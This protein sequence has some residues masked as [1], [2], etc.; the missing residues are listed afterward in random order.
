MP[1]VELSPPS[2]TAGPEYAPWKPYTGEVPSLVLQDATTWTMLRGYTLAAEDVFIARTK[3]GAIAGLEAVYRHPDPEVEKEARPWTWGDDGW[4]MTRRGVTLMFGLDELSVRPA[5]PV[6]VVEGPKD[7]ERGARVRFPGHVAVAR[8]GGHNGLGE[9]PTEYLAGRVVTIW[10][11]ADKVGRDAAYRLA[12]RLKEAGV[13]ALVVDTRGLPD[14]WGLADEPPAGVDLGALLAGARDAAELQADDESSASGAAT[15]RAILVQGGSLAPNIRELEAALISSNVGLYRRGLDLV[16]LTRSTEEADT[17]GIKRAAGALTIVTASEHRLMELAASAAAWFKPD[18]RKR[19]ELVQT[20]PPMDLLRSYLAGASERA[21][22]PLRGIVESPILR[23]DGTILEAPGYDEGTGL[24]HAPAFEPL[25]VA[26]HPTR[27]DALSALAVLQEPLAGFPFDTPADKS[28]ALAAILTPFVRRSLLGAPLF[29]FDAPKPRVGKSLLME[30]V[31]RIATGRAASMMSYSLDPRE[32]EKRLFSALLS[33]DQIICIDNIDPRRA[34]ESPELCSIL[35]QP[36]YKSRVLGVS[37]NQ[38]VS[39]SAVWLASGNNITFAADMADR[40]IRCRLDAKQEHPEDRVFALNED[41]LRWWV[42]EHRPRLVHAA[43]TILRAYHVAG[44]PGR[45]GPFGGFASWSDLVRGALCWLDLTD[46]CDTRQAVKADDPARTSTAA[47][48]RAWIETFGPTPVTTREVLDR[49]ERVS[50]LRHALDE[51]IGSTRG[52]LGMWCRSARDGV[53]GGFTLKSAGISGGN[54]R[55]KV[56]L[57]PSD[58]GGHG[59]HRWTSSTARVEISNKEEDSKNVN[60]M[61][62]ATESPPMSTMSTE[63]E[64]IWT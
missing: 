26:E 1:L 14:G 32:N 48:L 53:Y 10:P 64:I 21:H 29:A 23:P 45:P 41:G 47:L 35:T 42:L 7:R 16:W 49:A 9:M 27:D 43:L 15:R 61:G 38:E 57:V 11:D 2:D 4:K 52:N 62:R 39:T 44:R 3:D 59:G 30:V 19:G 8:M 37:K 24:Y 46:P 25:S 13:N 51:A 36:S 34:L 50:N 56:L 17:G 20:N 5:D 60:H 22:P 40:V 55:W 63:P 54:N 6:L 31:S 12:A 58:H 33:G 18:G 28:V